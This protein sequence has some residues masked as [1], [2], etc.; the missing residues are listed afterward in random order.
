MASIFI[1]LKRRNVFR[2]VI[3][4]AIIGWLLVEVASVLFPT[5]EAPAW[6]MKVFATVVILG[7][8]LAIVFAWIF[9][10]T[11]E[12]LKRE[13]EIDR[14]QSITP[15]TG[16]KLDFIIIGLLSVALIF[17]VSTHDWSDEG[18]PGWEE[19]ST[20]GIQSIAVLPF[21]NMSDDPSNEYFSDGI[22]EELLNVLVKVKGLQVASRTSSF[23]FK[24]REANIS[25][26]A[27]EL[28]VDHVLEGSVRKAGNTVRITAQLIDVRSDRHLWSETY[29]R[30]LED[31][32]AIQEE[33]SHRIVDALKI[34]LGAEEEAAI[35]QAGRPTENL[36]A[37]ELYLRGR[38]FWQRRGEENI[39]KAIDLF[40]HAIELDPLFAR[41]WSG[42]AAAHTTLPVYSNAL[43]EVH[44]PLAVEAASHALELDD[45]LAE[46]YAVL[47]DANRVARNWSE[48][49]T[50]YKKAIAS[51]PKDSTSHLWYAEHLAEVGRTR[52]ALEEALI[53]YRLDPLN[54]GTNSNLTFFY[55][56]LGDL[57]NT[58]RHGRTAFDLGHPFGLVGQAQVHLRRGEYD[59]AIEYFRQFEEVMDFQDR[60]A[61]DFVKA[62]QDPDK[63]PD[64]VERMKQLGDTVPL[65][66]RAGNL[67]A[68]DQIDDAYEAAF[69]QINFHDGNMW[70]FLWGQQMQSFRA[71]PRFEDL[72]TQLGLAD[73]WRSSGKW[74]DVCQP[75]D[76]SFTCQ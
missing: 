76:G 63:R 50:Y 41:A 55:L 1:E 42:L 13:T 8:P 2:V 11:P 23:S 72:V 21:V 40:E 12:G 25:E 35:S 48:A 66:V 30:E 71:D 26:I 75:Q 49:E 37:Y 10:M 9:E 15:R 22:S 44:M 27:E 57:D 39:R 4:Y 20:S 7:F 43:D 28:N 34:A 53:S 45:N 69:S 67:A 46:A 73:Y 14:S 29:D 18:D 68:L 5:F 64:F 62:L 56:Q 32:F 38:Y 17:F 51:E 60:F 16:R 31:I 54:P 52:E 36:E 24:D 3:A 33:I 47:A 58:A 59:Q 61:V 65:N 70:I 19:V 74:P 6:V